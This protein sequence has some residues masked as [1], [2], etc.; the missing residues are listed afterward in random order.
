AGVRFQRADDQPDQRGLAGAVGAQQSHAITAHHAQADVVEHLAIAEALVHVLE[1][2]DQLARALTGI[3]LQLDGADALAP[4][5]AFDAQV[6]EA[7][8]AAFVARAPRLDALADPHLFLRP[9]LVEAAVGEILGGVYL[10]LA[11]L[12]DRIVAR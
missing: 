1:L 4:L 6:F 3:D 8:H 12:V 2:G 9:E 11:L 7:L 5:R 10:G